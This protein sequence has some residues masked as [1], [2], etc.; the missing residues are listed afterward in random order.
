LIPIE[1][2]VL[3]TDLPSA[4]HGPTRPFPHGSTLVEAPTGVSLIG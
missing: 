2:D 3:S 1:S 4:G